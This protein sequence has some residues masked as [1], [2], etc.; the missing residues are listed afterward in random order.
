MNIHLSMDYRKYY[1]ESEKVSART[2]RVQIT[3]QSHNSS[4]VKLQ[5]LAIRATSPLEA[6]NISLSIRNYQLNGLNTLTYV[7][8]T[9]GQILFMSSYDAA[10][11]SAPETDLP[12]FQV[13]IV[14]EAGSDPV[15]N[16]ALDYAEDHMRI[17]A[18]T[19]Q[20]AH[21]IANFICCL[22]FNGQVRRTYI[23]CTEHTNE[24]Y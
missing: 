3:D 2:Y 18:W 1:F 13:T 19:A 7:R 4:N 22:P 11:N 8:D 20:E 15:D 9:A 17:H 14:R 21:T 24:R 16:H 5:E 23:Q 12:V 6:F 10:T